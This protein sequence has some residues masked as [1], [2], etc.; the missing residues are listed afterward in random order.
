M[1][2]F[3]KLWRRKIGVLT[4]VMALAFS[5]AWVRSLTVEDQFLVHGDRDTD[6]VLSLATEGFAW[7][8]V[9]SLFEPKGYRLKQ[10]YRSFK[11]TTNFRKDFWVTFSP[12][13]FFGE[14]DTLDFN[15]DICGFYIA[16]FHNSVH[17]MR[18]IIIPYWSVV[19]PLTL[20]S[21]WLLLSKPRSLK[22]KSPVEPVPKTEV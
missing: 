6:H 12:Q 17:H 15:I 11:P 3:F 14:G 9:R 16:Q 5:G 2:E 7:F 4:L 18:I 1:G 10:G 13:R 21:C 8:R 20:F 19:W 22:S